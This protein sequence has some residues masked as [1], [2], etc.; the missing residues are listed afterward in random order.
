MAEVYKLPFPAI[1]VFTA[2]RSGGSV[3]QAIRRWICPSFNGR[4]A[5]GSI[6]LTSMSCCIAV[7]LCFH[8]VIAEGGVYNTPILLATAIGRYISLSLVH[9]CDTKPLAPFTSKHGYT[10]VAPVPYWSFLPLTRLIRNENT[11]SRP[12]DP[13]TSRT[14]TEKVTMPLIPTS[15][16]KPRVILGLMTFGPSEK[17]GARITDL[18]VYNSVLD[19]FQ[20]RG[21]NEVDTARV[22]IAGQQEAFTREAKWKER[23]LTLA[24]KVK[25]PSADGD[26]VE[27]K[28]IESVEKSL[29]ELG[30]DCI[31]VSLPIFQFFLLPCT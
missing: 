19:K 1:M 16:G 18:S 20:S 12:G 28:V 22:Y 10:A 15:T 7:R 31:D 23:G 24:T 13:H 29:K 11:Q 26:H 2:L 14:K 5:A 4:A 25:Y 6:A 9:S 8:E 30:T 3:G 27:E 17:D 21:Y